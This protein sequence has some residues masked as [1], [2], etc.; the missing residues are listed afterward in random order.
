MLNNSFTYAY[1]ALAQIYLNQKKYDKAVGILEMLMQ[2]VPTSWK[3]Y[4]LIGDVYIAKR[5]FAKAEESLKKGLELESGNE[6][7]NSKLRS[8]PKY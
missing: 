3:P 6:H 1:Q 2:V 5:D 4:S 7:L 8:L